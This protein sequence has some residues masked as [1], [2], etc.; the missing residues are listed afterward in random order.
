MLEWSDPLPALQVTPWV[1]PNVLPFIHVVQ[2]VSPSRAGTERLVLLS[3]TL[4]TV[5]AL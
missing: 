3:A 2:E 1:C 4:D 5:H